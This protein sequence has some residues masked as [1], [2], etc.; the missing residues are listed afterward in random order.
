MITDAKIR[1]LK[2][3]TSRY[4]VTF[5]RGLALEVMPSG[6][7]TWKIRVKNRRVKIGT[8]PE[9]KLAA[10]RELGARQ[11]LL[12][13]VEGVF[14]VKQALAAQAQ[15]P[16]TVKEFGARY[17]EE[18]LKKDRKNP[19]QMIRI[20]EGT[21]YPLLG[22]Q[23]M[24][25]VTGAQVRDLIFMRRDGGRP[26]AAA[27]LRNL[28]KRLWDYAI[29]CDAARVNPAHAVPLKYITK[30]KSRRR[31]LTLAEIGKFLRALDASSK[32]S[33][34]YKI[35]LELLLLTM[36]RKS[37]LRLAT[38][39]EFNFFSKEWEIPAEHSKTSRPHIVYLS[40]LAERRAAELYSLASE[41]HNVEACILPAQGG[42][43]APISEVTLN[44][45]LA[46]VKFGIPHFTIHDLRRTAAT[47]LAEAGWPSDVIEKALNHTLKGIRGVYN[48][49]EFATQRREMLEAWAQMVDEARRSR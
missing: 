35:A 48:R 40:A 14:A 6:T 25:T 13:K 7:K 42:V 21:I 49:A 23:V 9:M 31:V 12:L 3:L 11:G 44:A 39:Q 1:A 22:G 18:R 41:K 34:R 5:E 43:L 2:P 20:L 37:E 45:A 28:I 8:F 10:A 36:V 26:A 33:H 17:I 19:R 38:W 15:R 24:E 47:H 27:A 16:P 29:V 4:T 32:V 30:S 46:R